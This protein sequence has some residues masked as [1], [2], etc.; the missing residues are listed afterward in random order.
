MNDGAGLFDVE[1]QL[2]S[3]H[4]EQQRNG[5][6]GHPTGLRLQIGSELRHSQR[7]RFGAHPVVLCMNNGF[8]VAVMEHKENSGEDHQRWNNVAPAAALEPTRADR[9]FNQGDEDCRAL[10]ELMLKLWVGPVPMKKPEPP[11]LCRVTE[12]KQEAGHAQQR[13]RPE[14]S[15]RGEAGRLAVFQKRE[16]PQQ[17][18]HVTRQVMIREGFCAGYKNFVPAMSVDLQQKRAQQWHR[19]QISFP[20]LWRE[21]RTKALG[22]RHKPWG[23]RGKRTPRSRGPVSQFFFLAQRLPRIQVFDA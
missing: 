4:N 11:W 2:E 12:E 21:T 8:M 10:Q 9:E 7:H 14:V 23:V 18:N 22:S 3:E 15:N 19:F 5:I 16:N 1:D 13:Q 6:P 17:N 20:I